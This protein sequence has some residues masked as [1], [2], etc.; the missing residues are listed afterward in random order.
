MASVSGHCLCESIRYRTDTD[1]IW[2]A[3]CHCESCRRACSAPVV[4]WM[5]FAIADVHWTGT[6]RFYPSSD[7]ASRGFCP[8][9]GTQMSFE[10][11]RW[12]GEVHLYAVSR[13]DPEAYV[14]KLQCHYAERL[15]WLESSDRL[16]KYAGTAEAP[17]ENPNRPDRKHP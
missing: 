4:A 6:R 2:T 10:S 9:C 8:T 14:P 5:G 17:S 12:P 3:L 13:E 16:P 1:P 11:T 7:I 15:A